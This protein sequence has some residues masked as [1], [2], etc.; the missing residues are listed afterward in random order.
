ME[1]II[2]KALFLS[3]IDSL[4]EFSFNLNCDIES[5]NALFVSMYSDN[6]SLS[7]S[8]SICKVEFILILFSSGLMP[9]TA[10]TGTTRVIIEQ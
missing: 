1:K 2:L 5:F 8:L 9:H 7:F 10:H 3:L 4:N 6:L